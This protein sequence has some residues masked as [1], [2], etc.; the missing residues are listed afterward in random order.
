MEIFCESDAIKIGM[1]WQGDLQRLKKQF[2]NSLAFK[3]PCT[4]YLELSLITKHIKSDNEFK[5]K[6]PNLIND[7]YVSILYIK[8]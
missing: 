1:S 5:T 2:P 4:P 7:N 6:L 8:L 3:S